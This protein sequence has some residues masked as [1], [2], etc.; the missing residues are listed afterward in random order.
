MKSETVYPWDDQVVFGDIVKAHSFEELRGFIN[1][2]ETEN[3]TK[4]NA[5]QST[6]QFSKNGRFF[7]NVI[8]KE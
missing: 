7:S 3:I 1:K 8:S 6:K 2:F 4:F 5:V